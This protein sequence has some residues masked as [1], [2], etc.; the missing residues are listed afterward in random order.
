[1][2]LYNK[3]IVEKARLANQTEKGNVYHHPTQ[4][5]VIKKCIDLSCRKPL[6]DI[7]NKPKSDGSEKWLEAYVIQLAKHSNQYQSP[8]QLTGVSNLYY[9]LDSQ[10][11]FESDINSPSRPLDCLL[12]EPETHN[13]VVIELKADRKQRKTAIDELKHYTKKIF[14]IK[15]EIADVFNL[16]I[17][18]AV[19][20]YIVW[21]GD[22]M[23]RGTPLPLED[24]G[25]I[26]YTANKIV[27][28]GKL[29]NPWISL[30]FT[31]YQPSKLIK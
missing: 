1:M 17:V 11:N 21:P 15:D 8:F 12:F 16:G 13:L 27:N 23:Y 19:E 9:F 7:K 10:R 28:H 5:H 22:D 18:S 29:T 3:E 2:A 20:G 31:K 14:E 6:H 24:W 25:L 4:T 26:G 30:M